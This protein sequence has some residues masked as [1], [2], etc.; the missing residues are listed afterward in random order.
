LGIP[1]LSVGLNLLASS[2]NGGKQGVAHSGVANLSI[3]VLNTVSITASI[4]TAEAT[5]GPC[6]ATTLQSESAVLDVNVSV[7]GLPVTV[8]AVDQHFEIDLSVLG[9]GVLTLHLNETIVGAN[10]ITQ[11]A[12]WIHSDLI[13]DVIV[14]E[15]IADVH[16]DP[17]A[18]KLPKP[19]NGF[20]TG[21]GSIASSAGRVTHGAHLMCVPSEGPNNLQVNWP[22]HRFHLESV[23][24]STC[25]NDL[26][27]DPGKPAATFDTIEGDGFG[28]CDGVS[29]AS[30]HWKLT[31][32]GEPGRAD[33]FEVS[34]N[35]AGAC[36]LT[37]AGVLTGGNHQ[38]H[39]KI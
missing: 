8:T 28:R 6:P 26:T 21:G 11:R 13:G 1:V 36:D 7:A 14:A 12:L 33:R 24:S 17:C 34:I 38:A 27:I 10:Q 2:T 16:G 23:T 31:D 22:G 4:L 15:A 20:M 35:G 32:A 25:S 29:N 37:A 18:G 3:N 30:V 39:S 19:R 9:L 5:A